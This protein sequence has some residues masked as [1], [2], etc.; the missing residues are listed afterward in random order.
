[1]TDGTTTLKKVFKSNTAQ[2]VSLAPYKSWLL[3]RLSN[4]FSS[5]DKELYPF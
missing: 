2:I 4:S 5:A 1:M 3:A